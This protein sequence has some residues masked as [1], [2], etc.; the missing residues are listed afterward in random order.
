M[1]RRNFISAALPAAIGGVALNAAA[2]TSS[3]PAPCTPARVA[4]VVYEPTPLAVVDTMLNMG[5]VTASDVI[6]DL[7][8]GDGRI[9][10]GAAK[11]GARGVG[12]DLNYNLIEFANANAIAERVVDQCKF[13]Y[14]D[15]FTMDLSTATVVTLYLLPAL[16]LR[17]R[18]KLW[19]ELPVGARVV[20]NA[21]DM[22]DWVPDQTVQIPTRYRVAYLW[23]IK[24]EHKKV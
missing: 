8:C 10:I 17:L 12:I 11:R 20:G 7:G 9:V 14:Q 4:D 2:Q 15:L 1:D 21:F 18:P 13:V 3:A 5:K 24:P 22:G 6:Y 16:N 23:T 19:R